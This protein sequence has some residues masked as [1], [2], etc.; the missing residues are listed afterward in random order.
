MS[1]FYN[2][3]R[4]WK[5]LSLSDTA[6]PFCGKHLRIVISIFCLVL[7]FVGDVH[8]QPLFEEIGESLG[9]NHAHV[10]NKHLGGGVAIFDFDNDGWQDV[11][12]T[13][14][15]IPD[16]LLKNV[17]GQQLVDVSVSSGIDQITQP[18]TFGVVTGDVDNDGYRD[19]LVTTE[20]GEKS[21][22][23]HNQGDGTFIHLPNAINDGFD[24]K[25]SAT[26]GD[27]NKDGLL[28]VYISAYVFQSGF[29][30]DTAGNV[31]AFEHECSP[32]QLF[33]NNG[34]L[35]FSN[36]TSLYGVGDVGCALAVAFTDFDNDTDVDLMLANDFGAW[37]VPSVL[38]ENN[39]PTQNLADIGGQSGMD[40]EIYGMGIAVGDYDK[41]ADLDYYQTNLGR[42]V[43]SRNDGGIF[44]DV[45]TVADCESDSTGQLLNTGWGTFFFDADNDSWPDLFVSNGWIQAAEIIATLPNDPNALFRNNG[46]GTFSD[47]SISAAIASDK[48]GRGAAY[49]DL[50]NDGRLDFVVNN[51]HKHVD[52]TQFEVYHN[53]S[54]TANWIALKLEGVQSNRD[55]FGSHVRI[56]SNGNSTIAEV[57]GGSSHASQ[58]SSIV[59]F[60]LGSETMIDSAVITFPSGTE[61]VI[62]SVPVNQVIEV[63]E[64]VT[65][66]N[67]PELKQE[68]L[69]LRYQNGVT[70]LYSDEPQM[71]QIRLF[72]ISGR[73]L[74]ELPVFLNSGSNQIPSSPMLSVGVYILD[75]RA[76]EAK[77]RSRLI[78]RSQ[79]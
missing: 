57:G 36:A 2:R 50:D 47:V 56:V 62:T 25:S 74:Y 68:S 34:N 55:A 11:Y 29:D 77:M 32:N 64:D 52:S 59:H 37:V 70:V 24:W 21:I 27:V 71:A 51:V 67:Q 41:D 61:R 6:E 66:S 26:F 28:D 53:I 18:T 60:G 40:L 9:I 14:G 46:D 76:E 79:Y 33:L 43:L 20:F 49:G 4:G 22:L 44:T 38:F 17:N 15:Q 78:V 75:V 30:L 58:N 31:I 1:D 72:D 13:G 16:K 23:M 63:V 3:S 48:R 8:S 12:L 54:N 45:T 7:T 10:S 39:Y 65:T 5:N 42:N 35:T 73:M 69:E 19:I